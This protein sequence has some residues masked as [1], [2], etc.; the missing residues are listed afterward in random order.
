MSF[1]KEKVRGAYENSVSPDSSMGLVLFSTIDISL[2]CTAL[3][4]FA[5]VEVFL[6]ATKAEFEFD[7]SAFKIQAQG[8]ERQSP[9]V[10]LVGKFGEFAMVEKQFAGTQGIVVVAVC[11]GIFG[12]MRVDQKEF[13]ICALAE[14]GIGLAQR[15]VARTNALDLA[16]EQGEAGF[17]TI[18]D[19]VVKE[20]LFIFA[21]NFDGRFG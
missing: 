20:G 21:Y 13:G 5:L 14:F 6:P 3:E 19:V 9:D 16:A 1:S 18:F 17:V 2:G 10:E 11:P 12:H 7:F 8:D 15:H 4:R